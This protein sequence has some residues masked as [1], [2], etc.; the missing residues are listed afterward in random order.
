[1]S[2]RFLP[3]I[4][5]FWHKQLTLFRSSGIPEILLVCADF[6]ESGIIAVYWETAL[7][8]LITTFLVFSMAF[9]M[10]VSKPTWISSVT[11]WPI[12]KGFAK[13]KNT[14]LQTKKK[15]SVCQHSREANK[16]IRP[17]ILNNTKWRP[18]SMHGPTLLW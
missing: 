18:K 12:V 6:V 15:K 2:K 7:P 4:N 16:A 14:V 5:P 13:E 9:R 8:V 10:H 17:Y 3:A 11:S 1:M